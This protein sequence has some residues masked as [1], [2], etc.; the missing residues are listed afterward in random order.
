MGARQTAS[1]VLAKVATEWAATTFVVTSLLPSSGEY[2]HRPKPFEQ[3]ERL[4][5]IGSR[6]PRLGRHADEVVL[7]REWRRCERSWQRVRA[8]GGERGGEGI[9]DPAAS[10]APR[11]ISSTKSTK[12]FVRV[13]SRPTHG[14]V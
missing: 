12:S 1:E 6:D 4:E 7:P 5:V 9:V 10:G 8:R 14:N 3:N 13:L 11:S 2:V